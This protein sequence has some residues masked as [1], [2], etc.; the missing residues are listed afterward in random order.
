MNFEGTINALIA[1][2]DVKDHYT[3]SHS[4]HVARWSSVIAETL[5]VEENETRKIQ[6]AA[7]MHDIGKIG[8]DE[9]IL[10]KDDVLTSEEYSEMKKHPEIGASI[11]RHVP[12]LID[13]VPVIRHHHERFDGKGYPD[14]LGGENIP[15]G[16]RIVMVADA[17]DA[18]MH[19]RPYRNSLPQKKI[20]QELEENAGTQFDPG[21]VKVLLKNGFLQK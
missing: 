13:V 2:I 15:L 21:I 17:I 7:H 20:Y 19:A 8:I 14:G 3:C 18:M 9:R 16:A 4:E 11:I 12:F 10:N 6:Q 1:T 5:G